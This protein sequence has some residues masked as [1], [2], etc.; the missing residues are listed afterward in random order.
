M[1][2]AVCEKIFAVIFNY[3]AHLS[4]LDACIYKTRAKKVLCGA[5]ILVVA[6]PGP[7]RPIRN[8]YRHHAEYCE[9][10]QLADFAFH[11][12]HPCSSGMRD[13]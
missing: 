11:S 13:A 8:D 4:G 2:L 1:P 6:I 9:Q 12:D 3:V 5:S 10:Q 7:H